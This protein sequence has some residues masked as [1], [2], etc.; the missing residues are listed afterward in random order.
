M[1]IYSK[2]KPELISHKALKHITKTLQ[3]AGE[4]QLEPQ[5]NDNMLHFYMNYIKPNLF[6]LI[7][8]IIIVIFL[9]T[10]YLL[11]QEKDK[12]IEK[13]RKDKKRKQ[14]Y[15]Q[16]LSNN[17]DL[18]S[19]YSVNSH[20]S[21]VN[22]HNQNPKKAFDHI[23]DPIQSIYDDNN[24]ENSIYNLEKEYQ[25]ALENNDG[26]LSKQAIKDMYEEKNTK[27]TFDE[28]AKIITGSD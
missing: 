11:K 21:P 2:S 4:K 9:F 23:D 18:Y 17:I 6:I 13:K 8:L 1:N 5:W 15:K 28:I 27:M 3:V 26:M 20:E 24:D 12:Y 10:R 22:N 14:K 7:V 16:Q 19:Q 25:T